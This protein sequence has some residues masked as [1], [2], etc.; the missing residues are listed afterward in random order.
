[1]FEC[2][3]ARIAT[4]WTDCIPNDYFIKHPSNNYSA[5]LGGLKHEVEDYFNLTNKTGDYYVSKNTLKIF[6]TMKGLTLC[7]DGYSVNLTTKRLFEIYDERGQTIN[8]F[9]NDGS[10]APNL[11]KLKPVDVSDAPDDPNLNKLKP[12][13]ED[14]N[15]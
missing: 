13:G 15:K 5:S 6:L 14:V 9:I 4:W 1:M 7:S 8:E 10:Y 11:N 2:E 12:V 3:I